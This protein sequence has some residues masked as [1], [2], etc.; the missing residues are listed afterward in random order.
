MKGLY[1]LNYPQDF[2]Q[3]AFKTNG[4]KGSGSKQMAMATTIDV[5]DSFRFSANIAFGMNIAGLSMRLVE[6][7][8]DEEGD[9]ELIARQ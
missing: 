5:Q 4:K 8:G 6:Y 1:K 7:S 3:L 2:K 9:S